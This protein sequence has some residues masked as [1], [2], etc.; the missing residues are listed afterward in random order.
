MKT[1]ARITPLIVETRREYGAPEVAWRAWQ[2]MSST[3]T[4]RLE[5]QRAVYPIE[6]PVDGR[7]VVTHLTLGREA[8]C[9]DALVELE[10]DTQRLQCKEERT[11]LA[12]L[13]HQ[14]EICRAEAG[15]L[16]GRGHALQCQ[17]LLLCR[18]RTV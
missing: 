16:T 14:L 11:R 17:P 13:T 5:V 9:G 7:V 15:V 1:P 18:H 4:A 2:C 8:Q 10:A 6:T 12:V 3:D